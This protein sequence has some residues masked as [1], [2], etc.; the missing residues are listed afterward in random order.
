MSRSPSPF[1]VQQKLNKVSPGA[2]EAG[3][4]DIIND[5]ITAV[6]ASQTALAALKADHNALIAKLNL[7]AGVTDVDYAVST[8]AAQTAVVP[9]T[10]R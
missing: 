1:S 2:A 8:A 5:L 10:S 4:G 6:T 7:D 9:L 3:L